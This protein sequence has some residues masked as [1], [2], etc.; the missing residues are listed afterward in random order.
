MM[1]GEAGG[2]NVLSIVYRHSHTK[3]VRVYVLRTDF[4]GIL[5]TSTDFRIIPT[6]LAT[7]QD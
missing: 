5:A 1:A 6:G 3:H 7:A 2:F 4:L